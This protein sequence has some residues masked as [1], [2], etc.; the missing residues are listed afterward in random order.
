MD[1]GIQH[2]REVDAGK[3]LAQPGDDGNRRSAWSCT[4]QTICNAG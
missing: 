3:A 2:Q 1:C 4:P